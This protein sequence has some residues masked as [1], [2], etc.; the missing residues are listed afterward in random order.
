MMGEDINEYVVYNALSSVVK[1]WEDFTMN[2]YILVPSN[3]VKAVANQAKDAK[4]RDSKY[5]IDLTQNR[6]LTQN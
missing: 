4:F 2:D 5:I 1:D 3:Y 6:N